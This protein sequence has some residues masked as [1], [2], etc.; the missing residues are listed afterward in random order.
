MKQKHFRD[1]TVLGLLLAAGLVFALGASATA[2]EAQADAAVPDPPAEAAQ[3]P[4]LPRPVPTFTLKDQFR[5]KHTLT[6]PFERV[7]VIAVG[8][9]FSYQHGEKWYKRGKESYEGKVDMH[10]VA[11][12]KSL[13][14]LWRPWLKAYMRK[15]VEES[16]L[17]DFKNKAPQALGYEPKLINLFVVNPEG[18]IIE[19]ITG[20]YTQRRFK[21][22]CAAIDALLPPEPTPP[23][24]TAKGETAK[25]APPPIAPR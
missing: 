2:D 19:H 8:D 10:A 11:A 9:E 18:Q 14:F 3:V 13:F 12:L 21:R 5:K 20:K 1:G 17:L 25:E 6:P 7:Q 15:H 24:E 23:P 22:L 4:N 16:V